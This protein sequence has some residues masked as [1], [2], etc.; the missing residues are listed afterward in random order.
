MFQPIYHV[1][2][3]PT[4]GNGPTEGQRKTLTRL[5]RYIFIA[6]P[7]TSSFPT[8]CSRLTPSVAQSV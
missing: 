8:T 3:S 5:C 7:L 6:V 1:S 4:G 2:V